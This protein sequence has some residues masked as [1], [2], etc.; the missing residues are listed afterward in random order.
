MP[1]EIETSRAQAQKEWLL[2]IRPLHTASI[3]DVARAHN[4]FGLLCPMFST[5]MQQPMFHTVISLT[6][7]TQ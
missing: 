7:K 3:T 5:I 2:I 4:V 6:K 1:T